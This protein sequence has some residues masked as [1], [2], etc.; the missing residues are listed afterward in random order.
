MDIINKLAQKKKNVLL[1][2]AATFLINLLVINTY[3]EKIK[4]AMDNNYVFIKNYP[5]KLE[6]IVKNNYITPD[7]INK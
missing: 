7:K 3:Y 2:L 6:R 4:S 1:F 5:I